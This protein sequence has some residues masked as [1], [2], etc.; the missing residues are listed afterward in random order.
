MLATRDSYP[1]CIQHAQAAELPEPFRSAD[2]V[3]SYYLLELTRPLSGILLLLHTRAA[4]PRGFTLLCQSLGTKLVEASEPLLEAALLRDRMRAELERAEAEARC[5][6]LTGLAN[7]LA[8]SESVAA[9]DVSSAEPVSF[10]QVD[11][12]RLKAINDTHGHRV[13]DEL[14][15]RVGSILRSCV[16][17]HDLVARLGGDE[18]AILLRNA[19]ETH[20]RGVVERIEAALAVDAG[21]RRPR[22]E[23]A[24]GTATARER[25]LE[26]AHAIA[27]SRMLEAKRSFG[28]ERRAPAA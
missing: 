21:S 10:V 13:G 28:G 11:C 18:F 3:L 12:R 19:D 27:D 22:L 7:R 2:G 26:A 1:V 16:R 9:A 15:V 20:A 8:W 24:L 14:L 5:D 25:P 4:G 17:E 23:L 6:P